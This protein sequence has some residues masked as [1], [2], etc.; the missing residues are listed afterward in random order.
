MDWPSAGK[1][2]EASPRPYLSMGYHSEKSEVRDLLLAN[3]H[4]SLI[5]DS[6]LMLGCREHAVR[7]RSLHPKHG[8]FLLTHPQSLTSFTKPSCHG[9]SKEKHKRMNSVLQVH[10]W[11][12]PNMKLCVH[13]EGQRSVPG[14]QMW[15]ATNS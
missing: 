12:C 10:L 1:G 3:G 11:Q 6:L 2:T 9:E 15:C 8:L 4:L 5:L 13:F 14:T 7:P